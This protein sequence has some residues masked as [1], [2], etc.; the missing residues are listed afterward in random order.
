MTEAEALPRKR[1][2]RTGHR[3]SATRILGQAATTL[4]EMP[5]DPD[6]LSLLRL[7]LDEKLE[8]LK[9]LDVEIIELIPEEALEEEI[10]QSE[11][12]RRRFM[13]P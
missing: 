4:A 11:S 5:L 2:I 12:T 6:R 8:T 3:A 9:S 7:T 10:Q 13:M 1:R